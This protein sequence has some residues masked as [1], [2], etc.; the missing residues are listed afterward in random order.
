[1][2]VMTCQRQCKQSAN[3]GRRPSFTD[4]AC[5]CGA[6]LCEAPAHMT[7]AAVAMQ[8]M[9]WWV[10]GCQLCKLLEAGP[11]PPP[12]PVCRPSTTT[13]VLS[14]GQHVPVALGVLHAG[15]AR[16]VMC[17]ARVR[18][19]MP[20]AHLNTPRQLVQ[21]APPLLRSAPRRRQ[22]CCDDHSRRTG[23]PCACP[24]VAKTRSSQSLPLLLAGDGAE[25]LCEP[26][27]ESRWQ[28]RQALVYYEFPPPTRK[29]RRCCYRQ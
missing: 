26:T 27:S 23:T 4:G 5:L 16:C 9:L 17:T 28:C 12:R 19:R 25:G 20:L 15:R 8:C 24:D 21:A 18:R 3:T 7:E 2:S 29:R 10:G 6:Q 11:T 13:A 14:S 1:M 22:C